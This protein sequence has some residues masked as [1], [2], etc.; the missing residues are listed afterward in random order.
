MSQRSF[1]I[2]FKIVQAKW[3][4]KCSLSNL[5]GSA[6]AKHG[7]KFIP[8][9]AYIR[10]EKDLKVND[11]HFNLRNE[12]REQVKSKVGREKEIIQ[13]RAKVKMIENEKLIEKIKKSKTS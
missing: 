6:K 4:W 8:L 13:I 7:G 3:K 11:I 5:W 12:K 9:N 10:K 2:H 1:K